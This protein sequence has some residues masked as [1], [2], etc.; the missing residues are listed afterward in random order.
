MSPFSFI[1][2]FAIFTIGAMALLVARD[3]IHIDDLERYDEFMKTISGNGILNLYP[4]NQVIK[5]DIHEHPSNEIVR[6][7]DFKP[8]PQADAYFKQ[9]DELQ[10]EYLQGSSG[11]GELQARRGACRSSVGMLTTAWIDAALIVTMS[12]EVVSGKNGIGPKRTRK[13]SHL[14]CAMSNV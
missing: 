2:S 10:A 8:S 4:E 9:E 6:S 13:T 14:T 1:L 5:L 11:E 7:A 12:G 3:A